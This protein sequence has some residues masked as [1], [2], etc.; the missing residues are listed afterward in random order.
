[1][2]NILLYLSAFIPLYFLIIIKQF[3]ELL[4]GNIKI[5]FLTIFVMV[6]LTVVILLG[7]LGLKL[8][9]I[10][11][12]SKSEKVKILSK[13]NITFYKR[14]TGTYQKGVPVCFFV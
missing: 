5:N 3:F 10:N 13:Q 9:I 2:K 6:F 1:M 14:K 11:N 4:M 8:E 7:L 12:K